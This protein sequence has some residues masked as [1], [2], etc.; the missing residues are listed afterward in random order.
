MRARTGDLIDS[1]DMLP[2]SSLESSLEASELQSIKWKTVHPEAINWMP[3]CSSV[4]GS[5]FCLAPGTEL[6]TLVSVIIGG[7]TSVPVRWSWDTLLPPPGRCVVP[8]IS[9]GHSVTRDM[10]F[11]CCFLCYPSSQCVSPQACRH[12]VVG[13]A[14]LRPLI[15]NP[16]S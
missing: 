6:Q 14:E 1:R 12:V 5:W 16:Q 7:I 2:L 13:K 3:R 4:M 15:D 9:T 8:F 10:G 11:L